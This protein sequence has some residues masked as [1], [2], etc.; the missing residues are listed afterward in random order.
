KHIRKKSNKLRDIH[1][2]SKFSSRKKPPSIF[3]SLH[4]WWREKRLY[5]YQPEI[6]K[7][8]HAFSNKS[9]GH[10]YL[11][12]QEQKRTNK[13]G[14]YSRKAIGRFFETLNMSEWV[15]LPPC[16]CSCLACVVREHCSI[17]LMHTKD[18]KTPIRGIYKTRRTCNLLHPTT[19]DEAYWFRLR[20]PT[21]SE[22]EDEEAAYHD[23]DYG[24]CDDPPGMSD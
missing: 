24:H 23:E 20:D 6:S 4:H 7:S 13:P 12:F 21:L 16:K 5:H 15:V 22:Q 3:S 17:K 9:M 10:R 2:V 19:A 18:L 11:Q 1:S 14:F 8:Y